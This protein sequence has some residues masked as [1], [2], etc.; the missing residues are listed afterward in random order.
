MTKKPA[1]KKPKP[2]TAVAV[3]EPKP[4]ANRSPVEAWKDRLHPQHFS[5]MSPKMSAIVGHVT[6]RRY[7]NPHI[8][9]FSTTSDGVVLA[10]VHGDIGFN[11]HIGNIHDLHQNWANL[12]D[13]AGLTDEQRAHANMAFARS[14]DVS[15][16][17]LQHRG[18]PEDVADVMI[19][20]ELNEARG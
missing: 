11:H 20:D 4:I 1:A 6:G 2:K 9:E 19:R 14:F 12:V 7:T 16:A 15:V 10:R 18:L 5:D 13:A 8:A 17:P 3:V